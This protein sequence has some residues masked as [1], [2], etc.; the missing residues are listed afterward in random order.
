MPSIQFKGKSIVQTLHL[1]IPYRQLTPDRKRSVLAPKGKPSLDDNLIIHGDNLLALKAL[2]PS[3]SG[4]VKCIYIDPPYNTG[5]EKWVYNDNVNHPMLKEWLNKEVDRDDL[6]RHDKWLCMMLPRLK[7]LREL[8][9]E[10]GVIFVS[11]DDNEAHR[12]KMLMDEIFG[13]ENFLTQV[14]WQKVYSPRMDAK[15]FS[16]DHDYI[17]VYRRSDEFSVEKISF[18]QNVDQFTGVDN[19]SGK[20]YRPRS[21]RKEGKNSRRSD[22]PNLFYPLAAP[23]GT[24]VFPI[25]SDGSEGCWRWSLTKY[26]ESKK[27]GLIEWA[28]TENGWQVYVKQFYSEEAVKPPS[29]IWLHSEVGH[30]HQAAD[31]VKNVFGKLV[32]DSPKPVALIKRILEIATDEED[33]ILDSCAGSGTTAHAVLALNAEDG[34]NRK[35]ILIEQEDYAD[36]IT[37]E[38]VRRVI[39]GVKGAK[40]E[41]LKKGYGGTF[42]FMTLGKALEEE[43]LL[44][45]KEMPT[46]LDLA[47]YVFFTATGQ[48]LDESNVDDK[49]FYLGESK[50]YEVY[51]IYKPDASFLKNTPL[52]LSFAES[53]GKPKGKTRLVI[54]SHKFLDEDRLR[55]MRIEFCQLPF[56]I[57]RFTV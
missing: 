16:V 20:R 2:L 22:R 47:R 19:V 31:E 29:T 33:I 55:E 10:D 32:F 30:N 41:Q 43:T 57:Y 48:Q 50:G 28:K 12:L 36:T 40:D 24:K 51:L 7:L 18:E 8:L 26:D 35:F 13:E 39:N 21:L 54:A 9:C 52:N 14:V 6:T 11:I 1:T 37:A 34:G 4:R 53:L 44:K 27:S 23:D 45:G 25:R 5:N 3:Y 42:S 46:Y 38:R 15:G 17:L 49:R 56:A